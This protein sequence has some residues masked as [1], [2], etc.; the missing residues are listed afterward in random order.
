LDTVAVGKFAGLDAAV[1][2]VL[3]N[4]CSPIYSLVQISSFEL[5]QLCFQLEGL[6]PVE[7]KHC[8]VC[9]KSMARCV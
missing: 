8:R 6:V 4:F 7:A 5:A 9:G 1:K 2:A 3:P